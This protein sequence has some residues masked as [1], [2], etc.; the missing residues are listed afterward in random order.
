[1]H[2]ERAARGDRLAV[3]RQPELVVR[4]PVGLLRRARSPRTL[5]RPV[6]DRVGAAEFD[7][8]D[9]AVRAVHGDDP[10]GRERRRLRLRVTEERSRRRTPRAQLR[11]RAPQRGR[12]AAGRDR[13]RRRASPPS[14]AAGCSSAG[15][16]SAGGPAWTSSSCTRRSRASSRG[17]RS[18]PPTMSSKSR[19]HASSSPSMSARRIERRARARL[20]RP[21]RDAEELGDLALREPA[22][23]GEGDHL[24]LALGQLLERA[25]HAPG[26]PALL[27]LVAGARARARPRPGSRPGVSLRPRARSTIALRATA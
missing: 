24:A 8:A 26:D 11:V 10:L 20:D 13:G 1:M 21:E 16:R 18:S 5:H 2:A 9:L 19:I 7:H 17:S 22:P 15:G 4:A 6:A 27:G 12:V 25:V 3:A 23:V 14:G